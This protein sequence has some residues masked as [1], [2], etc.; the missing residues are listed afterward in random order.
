MTDVSPSLRIRDLR[1]T[2]S[3]RS[4]TVDAVRG[5]DLD[6]FPGQITVLLGESGSGKSV[7]ARSVLRLYGRG[8]KVT[9]S[10]ELG[11]V[12]LLSLSPGEM[13]AVRGAEVA[14]VP[15]DP[16]A[17]LDPLRRVG[18]QLVEVLLQHKVVPGRKEARERSL[19][20][21]A[22]VGI[23]DPPRV[24]RSFPHELSGGLRQ[25]V[26]IAIA[27]SCDP[28][29]LLADE[30][31][32]ALDVTVQAQILDLFAGLAKRL[33]SA[34][35]LVTHDVGVAAEVGNQVGVMYAGRIVEFGPVDEVLTDPRHPYTAALLRSIPTPGVER[36]RLK[37]IQG[38]P[39]VSGQIP[40]GCPFAPRCPSAL[41]ACTE[42]DPDLLPVGRGRL[43]ACPVEAPA[44]PVP[45]PV[46]VT[47]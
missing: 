6:L 15:Q 38:Q 16:T 7:T 4:L 19:E 21:L 26:V 43:A 25:R 32:T 42:H 28:Q 24:A 37:S 2:F 18:A 27:V 36:G 10:A 46:E 20:L 45:V 30:P 5:V 40:A 33:G 17:S 13:L 1:T 8:A 39:P 29:V 11:G 47:V 41:P 9:G 3:S 23:P 44:V 34:V 14:M 31:T 12:D 35:L 22:S